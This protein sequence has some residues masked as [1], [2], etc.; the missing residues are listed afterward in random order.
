MK[1]FAFIMEIKFEFAIYQNRTYIKKQAPG[2]G[3]RE[4][5]WMIER[6][7]KDDNIFKV[8][9]VLNLLHFNVVYEVQATER[10]ERWEC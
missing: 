5:D 8:V 6:I 7:E 4:F 3:N 1:I 9:S 2:L 10:F